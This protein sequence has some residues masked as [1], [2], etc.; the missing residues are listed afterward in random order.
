MVLGCSGDLLCSPAAMKNIEEKL[1]ELPEDPDLAFVRLEDMARQ[2]L[3]DRWEQGNSVSTSEASQWAL[4]YMSD[5]LAAAEAY[6]VEALLKWKLPGGHDDDE[7]Y[8]YC[9]GFR[10]EA[11]RVARQLH[12]RAIRRERGHLVAFD[13]ATK[14]RLRHHLEQIHQ[15]VD[16]L[17]ISRAKKDR[18]HDCIE[19]LELEIGKDRTKVETYGALA[20][21]AASYSNETSNLLSEAVRKFGA[22][23]GL[24]QASASE[25]RYLPAPRKPKQIEVSKPQ[26]AEAAKT[27]K[28]LPKSSFEKELDDEVPF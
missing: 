2:E 9:H 14:V 16:K 22:A 7:E 15:I 3:E 24:A 19:D 18:L 28:Q 17:E 6:G 5:V 21:E 10:Q 1:Y 25:Q 26:Q 20:I 13:A 23:L 8:K 11:R 4:D 27:K 12:I